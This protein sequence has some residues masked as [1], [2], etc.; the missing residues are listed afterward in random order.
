MADVHTPEQRSRNMSAIKGRNTKPEIKLRKLLWSMGLRYRHKNKLPGRPDIVF[1][2]AK[3]V[4]F[5]DGCFWHRCPEHFKQPATRPE[6]WEKKISGNV[7][8][9]QKVNSL[10]KEDGWT[11]LRFWEHEIRNNVEN[12]AQEINIRLKKLKNI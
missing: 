1:P 11:V 2:S 9:D 3:L 4:V 8:R 7:E 10:L 12:V 6:F 5:V